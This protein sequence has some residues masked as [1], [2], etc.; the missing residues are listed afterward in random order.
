MR[1]PRSTGHFAQRGP[2]SP[3]SKRLCQVKTDWLVHLPYTSTGVNS[4]CQIP[5]GGTWRLSGRHSRI[6]QG[7]KREYGQSNSNDSGSAYSYSRRPCWVSEY[8]CLDVELRAKAN[9]NNR[10]IFGGMA[11]K[12]S[13]KRR[14]V[15]KPGRCEAHPESTQK[16]LF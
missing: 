13:H 3:E 14:T 2:E 10:H 7:N 15:T 12:A 16:R 11:C 9:P 5:N 1:W 4:P 6:C 8:A